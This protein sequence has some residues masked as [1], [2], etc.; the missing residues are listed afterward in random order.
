M[1][2]CGMA[3][4]QMMPV[5]SP[6]RTLVILIFTALNPSAMAPIRM[7]SRHF[8]FF[9]APGPRH[10]SLTRSRSNLQGP[11]SI[12]FGPKQGS[13]TRFRG[14][15]SRRGVFMRHRSCQSSLDFTSLLR[16]QSDLSIPTSVST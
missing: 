3:G 8:S 15:R 14:A 6:S 4:D 10:P 11:A 7:S 12:C 2:V 13:T 16:P 9:P 1:W 5:G